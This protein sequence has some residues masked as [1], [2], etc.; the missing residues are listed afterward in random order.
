MND[1]RNAIRR[2]ASRIQ[3]LNAKIK[4]TFRIKPHGEAHHAACAIFHAEYDGLAF[5]GGLSAAM[6]KLK[7]G[8]AE[9][10][11]AAVQFLE[12]LPR[13]FRS[14]YINEDILRHL[15]HSQL[16]VSQK[17]RLIP[18]I[19]ATLEGGGRR[20]FHACA[21]LAGRLQD[22]RIQSRAMDL[23][24]SENAETRLRA[25][26]II[27]IMRSWKPETE[28]IKSPSLRRAASRED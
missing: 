4:E 2:N 10:V 15:K 16:T 3:E 19:I 28:P 12:V 24:P 14:G 22:K 8:D 13:F 11:E 21:K 23:L 25:G 5:P 17:D 26:V 27:D 20:Q 1:Y 6:P 7:A 18:I 9:T